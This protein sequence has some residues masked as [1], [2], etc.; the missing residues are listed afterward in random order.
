MVQLHD[1]AWR[2][3]LG[4]RLVAVA[5]DAVVDAVVD[6]VVDAVVDAVVDDVIVDAVVDDV[7][8]A[9]DVEEYKK[10]VDCHGCF[11]YLVV[12]VAVV[13]A[14]ALD[15]VAAVDVVVAASDDLVRRFFHPPHDY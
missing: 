11:L 3:A 1:V 12:D 9:D 2:V 13:A 15:V 14:V 4:G 7:I 8:V 5:V 10:F 6:V